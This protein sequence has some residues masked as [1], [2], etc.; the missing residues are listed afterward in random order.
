MKVPVGG[1]IKRAVALVLGVAAL[2]FVAGS[3]WVGQS[4][5]AS[6]PA[7]IG[8][9]PRHLPHLPVEAV[10]IPSESGSTLA[11]WYIPGGRPRGVIVLMH[12]SLGSRL[13]MVGRADFLW[14]AGYSVLLFDFQAHGESPGDH[15]TFGFLESRDARA[16]VA[17]A[18]R[19]APGAPV[20]VIGRSLG[21]AAAVLGK[22]PLGVQAVVLEAVYPTIQEAVANRIRIRLG[23]LARVLTPV[24]VVQL[25]PRLGI[26]PQELRPIDHVQNIGAPVL[27]AA[28]TADR[29]TRLAESWRLFQAARAPKELWP[30]EGAGHVDFHRYAPQAYEERI[31]RFFRK[32]LLGEAT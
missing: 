5:V 28:G 14:R 27:M 32:H 16:A 25:R 12:Q 4:M 17:F 19:R 1:R 22:T 31:L 3:L 26:P 29:H 21:G 13:S 23:P 30:V 10:R 11:A 15:R 20:G 8:P 9:A 6:A 2:L 24:L 7:V 18:K